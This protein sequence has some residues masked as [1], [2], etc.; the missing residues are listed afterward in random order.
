MASTEQSLPTVKLA[1]LDAFYIYSNWMWFDILPVLFGALFPISALQFWYP[2]SGKT[3]TITGGAENYEDRGLIP[4]TLRLMFE[5]T[6]HD[7]MMQWCVSVHPLLAKKRFE[8][9]KQGP[10]AGLNW[11]GFSK[12]TSPIP[13]VHLVPGDIPGLCDVFFRLYLLWVPVS[14][15]DLA[16]SSI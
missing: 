4:R 11:T 16:H 1:T 14:A 3:F 9:R 2:G 7:A 10:Q 13:H 12:G 6:L 5:A 8:Q 15:L